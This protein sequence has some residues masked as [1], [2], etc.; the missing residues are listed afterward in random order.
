M[1]MGAQ[2][3]AAPIAI[4]LLLIL[5]CPDLDRPAAEI[6]IDPMGDGEYCPPLRRAAESLQHPGFGF[7]I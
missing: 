4:V 6:L 3:T 2:Q 1:A 7:R 5:L